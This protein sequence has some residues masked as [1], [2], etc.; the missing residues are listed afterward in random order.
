MG[1]RTHTAARLPSVNSRS[2]L[3][4]LDTARYSMG[5]STKTGIW[6][7]VFSWYLA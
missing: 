1:G 7:S 4:I 6:R 2:V 3:R 5:S